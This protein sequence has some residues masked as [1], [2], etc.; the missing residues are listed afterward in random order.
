MGKMTLRPYTVGQRTFDERPVTVTDPGYDAGTW[1]TLT[2][3]KVQPGNYTCVAWR[4][5]DQWTYEGK[6][7]SCTRTMTCG[8]YLDG[9]IPSPAEWHSMP[10]IGNIGVDAGMAGF[11]QDK[12]DYDS[13]AWFALCDKLTNK[14]WMITD[15][16]F[17]TNSG[18]GDGSY[19]VHG[20]KNADG[21][22]TALEIRF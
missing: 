18:Y 14:S 17:F 11:F 5:R 13:D 4:G 10:V 19:D 7:Y 20:I 6:R 16:G 8:I 9:K 15:E 21:L 2:G 3:I 22:Y 1:C 12:P